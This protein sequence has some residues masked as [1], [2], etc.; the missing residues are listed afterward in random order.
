MTTKNEPH[1]LEPRI[2]ASLEHQST[3]VYDG[4]IDGQPVHANR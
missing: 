4:W 1:W 2:Q 3:I